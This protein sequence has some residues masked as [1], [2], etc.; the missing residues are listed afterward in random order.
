MENDL[1]VL[2]IGLDQFST[3]PIAIHEIP[4][5]MMMTKART[6]AAVKKS[7]TMVADLTL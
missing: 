6:L 5:K 2:S 4:A 7:W 3:C 1:P